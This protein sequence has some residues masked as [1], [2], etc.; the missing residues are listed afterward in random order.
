MGHDIDAGAGL[1]PLARP[2]IALPGCAYLLSLHDRVP[3]HRWHVLPGSRPLRV[4]TTD[5][6]PK[7]LAALSHSC[8]VPIDKCSEWGSI[9]RRRGS[10]QLGGSEGTGVDVSRLGLMGEAISLSERS[11]VTDTMACRENLHRMQRRRL[12]RMESQIRCTPNEAN[13]Y[14]LSILREADWKRIILSIQR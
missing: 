11:I 12:D 3:T 6:R 9:L 14:D 7:L 10:R 13:R 4:K 1:A 2:V 5:A 8:V